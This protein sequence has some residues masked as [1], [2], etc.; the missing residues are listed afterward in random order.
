MPREKATDFDS[1][2]M[3]IGTGQFMAPTEERLAFIR[4]LGVGDI[5]LNLYQEQYTLDGLT[6]H[7]ED[8]MPLEGKHEWAY[9]N[10]LE[11][12][13]TVEAAGLRLTAIENVPLYFYDKIMLQREGYEEQLEHMKT[14]VR[15]IG[16]AGIP[17]FGYHWMPDGVQRT[18]TSDELVRGGAKAG[19]FDEDEFEHE[20]RYDREYTESELWEYYEEFLR[21]ILP[22]AEEAGVRMALHP[23]DPPIESVHG[24]PQLFRN[25]ESF[26]K[27]L[28]LVPS[29][30]HGVELCLGCFSE[31]GED[32][33]EAIRTLGG[34]N[35]FYVHFRDVQGTATSF[36]EDWIDEGQYDEFEVMKALYDGG[37][38]GMMIPDHVPH[39]EGDTEWNHSGRS[40]T[41]G[42]LRG[43]LRCVERNAR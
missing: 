38:S 22:V 4:Q 19:Y 36:H 33:A 1:L 13:K 25:L 9:E 26:Q 35:I 32:P 28:E 10:L 24:V 31:M 15:N 18:G 16:R 37:F 6:Y 41:I 42:Y 12:R 21:E 27:A 40:Y 43:V 8:E 30:H 39:L 2:P 5:N 11:L 34:E 7:T 29:D 17:I 3:R 23:N 14:T 20:N